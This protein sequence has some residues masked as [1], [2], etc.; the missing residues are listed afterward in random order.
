V[1]SNRDW[2]DDYTL[3][4]ALMEQEG[5]ASWERWPVPVRQRDPVVLATA[6]RRLARRMDFLRYVQWIAAVQWA[7]VRHH[8]AVCGVWLYGDLPF[9]VSRDSADVWAHRDQFDLEYTIGT[10]PDDFSVAG[11]SWNLPLYHWA[12]MRTGSFAWW[13]RRVRQASAMYEL[14]RIDHIVGFFRTYAIPQNTGHQGRF[15]PADTDD[16]M[17]QGRAFLRAVLAEAEGA[18]PI[19]EDLGTVPDWVRQTLREFGIPGYKV[20]RWERPE[21]RYIDP[22]T[23]E[24]SSV[25]TTGTHDTD[26]LADWWAG[27]PCDERGEILTTLRIPQP[28]DSLALTPSLREQIIGRLYEAGSHFVIVPIQDLFGWPGRINIP[29]TPSQQNWNW[30]LPIPVERLSEDQALQDQTAALRRLVVNAGRASDPD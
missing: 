17:D 5:I 3:Y 29:S 13:R 6:A 25:A 14:F 1:Q 22:R 4:R 24:P 30:R 12:H 21:E 9:A 10:P 23:Y 11:Q 27:L 7:H 26:N 16:Q 15:V 19:A 28:A 18:M 20:L 8:A 2:L